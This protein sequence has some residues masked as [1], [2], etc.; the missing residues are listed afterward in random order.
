MC[1][2]LEYL[3]RFDIIHRDIKPENILLHENTAKICD[4]GWAV[5]SPL[6]RSTKCGT[7]IYTCPE[8][9]KEESYHTKIDIWCVGVLTYEL[10]YAAAPF[11][12]K[13]YSDFAKI[14]Y[15]QISFPSEIKVSKVAKDFMSRCMAKEVN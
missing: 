11:Q 6:L 14:V 3:H 2:A 15:E 7:P 8:I 12:I 1:I 10:L 9:V 5:H 13:T 4:F